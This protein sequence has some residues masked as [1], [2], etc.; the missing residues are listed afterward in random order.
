MSIPVQVATFY[1]RIWNAGDLDA[2]SALLTDAFEFRGSLGT[3]LQGRAEFLEY[4]RSIRSALGDYHCE[5]LECVTEG[6]RAFAQMR[7]AGRHIG[8][9]RGFPPTGKPVQ[10]SGAALFRFE[11]PAIA[12]LWVLGD[13]LGLEAV[14][15]ANQDHAAPH[16][17]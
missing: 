6:D 16:C 10:W 12:Q 13:V 8:V 17:G 15:K 1:G 11:G 2:A 4:V 14:L 9:F 3:E 5:I 7:F